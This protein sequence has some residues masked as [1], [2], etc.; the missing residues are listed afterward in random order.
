VEIR[1]PR[2][3]DLVIYKLVAARPRDLED[4]EKVGEFADALQDA[5][6]V[7]ALKQRLKS[8]GLEP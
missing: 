4:A 1:V 5:G 6:R 8:T 2:A 3:D 7:D